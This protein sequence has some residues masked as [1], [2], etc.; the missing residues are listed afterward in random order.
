M[1]APYRTKT[2]TNAQGR[3]APDSASTVISENKTTTGAKQKMPGR[4][5]RPS[6][7]SF[8]KGQ[9]GKPRPK[10]ADDTDIVIAVG[11]GPPPV[12]ESWESL[13]DTAHDYATSGNLEA[14]EEQLTRALHY[15]PDVA[16]GDLY[17]QR[18]VVRG[19]CGLGQRNL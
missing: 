10:K 15:A 13:R 6:L 7:R 3:S 16:K 1:E 2:N 19:K 17:H 11:G 18:S 5:S 14:A 4:S 9:K 8:I 12:Q